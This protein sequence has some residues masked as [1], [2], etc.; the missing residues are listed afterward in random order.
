MSRPVPPPPPGLAEPGQ[1]HDGVRVWNA[2]RWFPGDPCEY[3]FL[4]G[5]IEA[6]ARSRPMCLERRVPGR[7]VSRRSA[8]YRSPMSGSARS[9]VEGMFAQIG[10]VATPA[11]PPETPGPW[12]GG[13]AAESP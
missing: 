3:R 9:T 4:T 7:G 6:G 13:R 5:E 11:G 1:V 8:W 12:R 2:S 10:V